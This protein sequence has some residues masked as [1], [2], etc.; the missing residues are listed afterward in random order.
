MGRWVGGDAAS[1][2]IPAD[3]RLLVTP[4]VLLAIVMAAL[5]GTGIFN[6]YIQHKNTEIALLQAIADL[7]ARQINELA[8]GKTRRCGLCPDQRFF[9]RTVPQLAKIRR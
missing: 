7:K 2:F 6:T 1:E 8:Q 3:S 9:C 5:T 4:F